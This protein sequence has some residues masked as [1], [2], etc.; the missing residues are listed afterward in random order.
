MLLI[1]TTITDEKTGLLAHV[2]VDSLVDG[3]A[4]GGV[5]MTPGVTVEELATLA[6]LMTL[7]LALAEL[8]LGGAKAGIVSDLRPGPERDA[9]L[10]EFGVSAAPLLKGGIYLGSDQGITHPDRTMIFDAAGYDVTGAPGARL[11]CSWAELWQ[12][13]QDITGFGVVRAIEAA[14]YGRAP[15]TA[16]IQGFGTVGRGAARHLAALGYRIV[17]VADAQGTVAHPGGLP[18]D[19]LFAATDTTG[20]I[21]RS[22]LPP[23]VR[24]SDAPEAWLDVP[25]EILVLAAGGAAIRREN[26]DRVRARLVVEGANMPCTDAALETLQLRKIPVLPGIVANAG[27]A[28]ATALVLT[29]HAPQAESAE[30]LARGLREEVGRRIL[31]AYRAVAERAAADDLT[32][33]QAAVRHALRR[34][35]S[36]RA[37]ASTAINPITVPPS[38]ARTDIH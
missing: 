14:E 35:Y 11:P 31:A 15:S 21:D 10:R 4:M 5:R 33:P 3:R 19:A 28:A 13:C 16:V 34:V 38:R 23:A 1:K 8:P 17:A 12:K 24:T 22:A 25:A 32:L 37:A 36:P 26:A 27:A 20:L 2:A 30:T 7:K 6:R 18:L 29:G 9:Q